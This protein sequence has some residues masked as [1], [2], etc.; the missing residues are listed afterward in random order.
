MPQTD[1]TPP[2]ADQFHAE[3]ADQ[4]RSWLAENHTTSAGI[5]LVWWKA[6]T[7][8]PRISYDDAVTEALAFGWVDSLAGT[9]DEERSRLRFTPRKP[10][11]GWS[12]PNKVRI[13]RLV[14]EGRL[15][16]A[17]QAAIDAAKANGSWS[18]LDDV[19]DLVVPDDL[20]A[21]FDERPGARESWDAFPRS[22]RR[23]AL[24]WIVLAKRPETRA[25]RITE[26]ADKS[27]R[28]ER[29]FD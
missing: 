20:A 13:E 14:A 29:V 22:V 7:L 8:R 26:T 15:H 6:G 3:T 10:T 23:R 4:W 16:L 2:A 21:A 17:G 25:R 27:A 24:E 12:R 19:E 28:G 18:L 9:V 1:A 5:W 11:S